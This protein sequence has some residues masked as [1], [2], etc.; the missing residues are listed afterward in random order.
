MIDNITRRNLFMGL[1]ATTAIAMHAGPSFAARPKRFF[2]RVRK[3]I[4]LQLYTLGDDIAK[5][6]D[7]T[8]ASVAAIGFRD[9]QLPQLYGKSPAELKKAADRAGVSF[10]CLH[11]GAM[12]R[13]P[14]SALSMRS[15]PQRIVDDLG[16]LGV[17]YAV[18]PLMLLPANVKPNAGEN[19][20]D[21]M[22]RS[23]LAGGPDIWKRTADLLNEK[24]VALK[25]HGITIGYHNHNLEF[26]P[27]AGGNGWDILAKATDGLVKFEVDV[28]WL[29]AAGVDPVAFL[30]RH[31][32]RVHSLHIKDLLVSTQPNFA[33]AMDPTEVGSGKQ[34]WHRILPAAHIAGCQY[35]YVEQEAPFK[36][37]RIDAA[38][39]AHAFLEGLKA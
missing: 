13:I 37:E 31:K 18:L 14:A 33:L 3:P 5:D 36:I 7:S 28:G 9:L 1:A 30:D 4:G 32:G 20:R 16:A 24:A 34:D 19:F 10:S 22:I 12:D 26:A 17:N 2:E 38:A 15:A 21:A 35:Y 6:I 29:A 23:V 8:L 25:P 11:L 27:V 39:K